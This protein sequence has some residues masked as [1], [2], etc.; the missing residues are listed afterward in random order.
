MLKINHFPSFAEIEK[1]KQDNFYIYIILW[2]AVEHFHDM[3]TTTV[4][5]LRDSLTLDIS[6]M[7][8][9]L[10]ISWNCVSSSRLVQKEVRR[11]DFWFKV[12]I[13]KN[14]NL[15]WVRVC[16][17]TSRS[18]LFRY[19][20][21]EQSRDAK[22]TFRAFGQHSALNSKFFQSYVVVFFWLYIEQYRLKCQLCESFQAWHCCCCLHSV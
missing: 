21:S 10:V 1:K 13:I 4:P 8:D 2:K 15:L 7:K 5:S 16:L 17:R 18:S 12:K 3:C 14:N 11:S 22:T 20:V 9:F 19:R 6:G